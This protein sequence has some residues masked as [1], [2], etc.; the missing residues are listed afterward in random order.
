MKQSNSQTPGLST[1]L[2]SLK[3]NSTEASIETLVS[4]LKRRQIR[5]SRPC[6][7]ATIHLMLRVVADSKHRDT[8]KLMTRIRE[9]GRRLVAAQPRELVVGNIVRRV[10]GL[11]REIQETENEAR[12]NN[13]SEQSST[14]STPRIQQQERFGRASSEGRGGAG[15][16]AAAGVAPKRPTTLSLSSHMSM[17][18]PLRHGATHA[19]DNINMNLASV[20]ATVQGAADRI[21]RPPLL[22][23]G[24]S[25]APGISS[26][27]GIFSAFPEDNSG[28]STPRSAFASPGKP[29]LGLGSIAE[30]GSDSPT[31]PSHPTLTDFRPE[32]LEGIREIIDELDQVD[33]QIA[34]FAEDHIHSSEIILT[35]SS[36]LTV[37]KFLLKVARKRRFTVVHVESYPNDSVA[38][39][40]TLLHGANPYADPANPPDHAAANGEE[41]EDRWKPLTQAGITVIMIPDSAVYALMSRVNKVLLATHSVLANGG[42]VASAGA[43]TIAAAAKKH[44]TPVVVL[45]GVYKLSPI[46]PFDMESLIEWGEADKVVPFEEGEFVESVDVM[47]PIF[48]YVPPELVDLYITNLG[49]HAPSYLYRIVADHYH[50]ADTEL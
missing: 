11:V 50:V 41:G 23:A 25:F 21:A 19:T 20:D 35:H 37:Q 36:S 10:L 49:G 26:L 8:D 16:G 13:N 38:T 24:T 7:I 39:Y 15:A 3:T 2:K 6:A 9:V 12:N 42:L 31:R 4:L 45:S 14:S 18:S 32:V 30:G 1:Y 40:D 5:N 34:S 44:Q 17:Y 46:Y 43:R 33:E 47:N 29:G 28:S 22:P 48:D 27:F